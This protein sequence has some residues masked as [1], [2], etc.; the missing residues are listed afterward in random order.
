MST[1]MIIKLMIVFWII[2]IAQIKLNKNTR[3]IVLKILYIL[4]GVITVFG[5]VATTGTLVYKQLNSKK[6]EKKAIVN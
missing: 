5:T 4:T 3:Q 1:G 6:S 2:L